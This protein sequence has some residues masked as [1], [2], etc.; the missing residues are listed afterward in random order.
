MF[1]ED[2]LLISKD[3]F[4]AVS[5]EEDV[6]EEDLTEKED[7]SEEEDL[8]EEEDVSE[9]SKDIEEVFDLSIDDLFIYD[10]NEEQANKSV[11]PY[12]EYLATE[13]WD[14]SLL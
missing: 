7:V 2:D 5:E 9:I 6:S 13:G 8:T 10:M 1:D 14:I 12:L 11:L 4:Y 3:A